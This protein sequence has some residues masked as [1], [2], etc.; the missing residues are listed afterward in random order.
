MADE[1]NILL[2]QKHSGLIPEEISNQIIQKT[3]TDSAVMKL[4]RKVTMEQPKVK[5]PVLAD[6]TGKAAF[7]SELQ[8]IP[9]LQPKVVD[10]IL[11]A[12][13]L[14]FIIPCSGDFNDLTVLD[15]M[16]SYQDVITQTLINLVDQ[17]ILVG[18]KEIGS[19]EDKVFPTVLDAAILQKVE[20]PEANA[21]GVALL[22]GVS[23]AMQ[24]V[25]DNNFKVDGIL[26][27]LGVENTLR[28]M[29]DTTNN[30]LFPDTSKL[31]GKT[32][33]Y[34]NIFTQDNAVAI[35]GD[36]SRC[37]FGVYKDIRYDFFDSGTVKIS[38]TEEI[39]LIQNYAAALRITVY[40][41]S[42]IVYKDAFSAVTVKKA[43]QVGS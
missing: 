34:T 42:N 30:F 39:N 37:L 5:V 41:A 1:K 3:L 28:K 8:S 43:T 10:V 13:R 31:F 26:G 22:D 24:K 40:V 19:S 33:N 11:E 20:V 38:E 7:V 25:T 6:V 4:C 23:D 12:K 16:K 17:S 36:W 29:K 32:M 18:A 27:N 14:S 21:S 15:L 35:V 2:A 9:I